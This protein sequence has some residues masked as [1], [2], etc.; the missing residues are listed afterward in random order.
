M[1]Y[2]GRKRPATDD[3]IRAILKLTGQTDF[4]I[5]KNLENCPPVEHHRADLN[6]S[7]LD[8]RTAAKLIDELVLW[9]GIHG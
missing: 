8:N 1:F 4:T 2:A 9:K 6:K 7:I 5:V 3:Q